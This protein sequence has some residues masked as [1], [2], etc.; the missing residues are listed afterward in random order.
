MPYETKY[1]PTTLKTASPDDLRDAVRLKC[2]N[3]YGALSMANAL[4]GSHTPGWDLCHVYP[5]KEILAEA[6]ERGVSLAG[7]KSAVDNKPVE[8]TLYYRRATGAMTEQEFQTE[9]KKWQRGE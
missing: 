1:V 4:G 5:L 3:C 9:F 8:E 7:L 6:T 2:A